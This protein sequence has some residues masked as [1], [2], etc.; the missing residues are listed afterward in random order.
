MVNLEFIVK[1]CLIFKILF[2]YLYS[3][4]IL[5]SILKLGISMKIFI[6]IM[7][8]VGSLWASVSIN[9]GS[10]QELI[11]LKGIGAKTADAI[12]AHRPFKTLSDLMTVKGIGTKKF[13]KIKKEIEL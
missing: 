11:T 4:M 9:K 10:K 6:T 13:E 12:I 5:L 1:K 8:L 2:N 7:L 3:F